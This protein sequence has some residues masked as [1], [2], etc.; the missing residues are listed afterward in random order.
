[1]K[2]RLEEI[3][4]L[5][6]DVNCDADIMIMRH[7]D[8]DEIWKLIERRTAL[9]LERHEL[10]GGNNRYERELKRETR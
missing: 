6:G 4:E 9:I 7:G 1:M 2:T 8:R 10:T 5:L 3:E